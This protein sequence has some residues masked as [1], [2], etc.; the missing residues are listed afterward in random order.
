[1]NPSG[2]KPAFSL[3]IDGRAEARPLQRTIY[4]TS[5]SNMQ[6][7]TVAAAKLRMEL[8]G[9]SPRNRPPDEAAK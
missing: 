5:S 1:V 6:G 7:R 9:A 2:L 4:E 8:S 3:A